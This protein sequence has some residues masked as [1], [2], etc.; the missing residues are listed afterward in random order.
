MMTDYLQVKVVL[1]QSNRSKISAA[2][3]YRSRGDSKCVT[4]GSQT[5]LKVQHHAPSFP[6]DRTLHT[7]ASMI[8][9][10]GSNSRLCSDSGKQK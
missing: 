6:P 10:K 9:L 8:A 2:A 7:K 4:R 1:R 5:L 3:G